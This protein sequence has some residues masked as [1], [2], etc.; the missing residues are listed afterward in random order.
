MT[1][2]AA[3]LLATAGTHLLS[4]DLSHSFQVAP[5]AFLLF[6]RRP[7]DSV[8]PAAGAVGCLVRTWGSP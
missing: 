1:L 3:Q 6:S 5:A 8:P 7:R 2:G 4:S